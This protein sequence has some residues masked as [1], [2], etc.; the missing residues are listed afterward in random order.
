M[1][2]PK[3][4]GSVALRSGEHFD[5]DG[6]SLTVRSYEVEGV[7]TLVAMSARPFPMPASSHLLAGSSSTAWMATHGVFAMYGVNRPAGS[8]RESMFLVAAMPMARLPQV[9]VRLHLI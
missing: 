6:Q 7:V 3:V 4:A 2:S 1:M 9:A 8:G 5:I